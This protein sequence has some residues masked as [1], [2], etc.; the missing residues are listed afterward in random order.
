MKSEPLDFSTDSEYN[1][2]NGTIVER[3]DLSQLVPIHDTACKHE[4]MVIDHNDETDHYYALKCT[5][6]P[7]GVLISKTE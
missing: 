5:N 4:N 6:C 2:S 3:I 7:R 1:A